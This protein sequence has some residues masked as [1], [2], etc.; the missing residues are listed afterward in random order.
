[1]ANSN[2]WCLQEPWDWQRL[3]IGNPELQSD[4]IT[5]VDGSGSPRLLVPAETSIRM[6]GAHLP[7][8]G[9]LVADGS[10]GLLASLALPG[11]RQPALGLK[12]LD[13][14]WQSDR[15]RGVIKQ[16]DYL[17]RPPRGDTS[18]E[19]EPNRQ[20]ECFILWAIGR[21]QELAH[22]EAS[23]GTGVQRTTW[24]IARSVWRDYDAREP[25]MDLIVRL[26]KDQEL[27]EALDAVSRNPR[28]VLVRVRDEVRVD[29][30][31]ELDAACIRSYARRP[32]VTAVEKAGTRQTLLAVRRQA[33]HDTL[34]NRVTAWTLDELTGCSQRWLGQHRQARTSEKT[35]I[36]RRLAQECPV[37]RNGEALAPVG[38]ASLT[39][40]TQP[41]YPLQFAERYQRVYAAYLKLLKQRRE[42]D[43]A[44]TWRRTLW[45]DVVRQLVATT[46]LQLGPERFTSHPHYRGES[47]H[48]SWLAHPC[49]PGP[50]DVGSRGEWHVLDARDL[51]TVDSSWRRRPPEPWMPS[52]GALGADLWLWCLRPQRLVPIWAILDT[53]ATGD[54]KRVE[55]AAEA[56][57]AWQQAPTSPTKRGYVVHGLIVTSRP[58]ASMVDLTTS[59]VTPRVR[60]A[61]LSLPLALGLADSAHYRR[62]LDDVAA[63]IDLALAG[64]PA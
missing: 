40:P 21:F 44:W 51:A 30:V 19:A 7:V 31:Q 26:A 53:A 1:M 13:L 52:L 28:R 11:D 47:V 34:E 33:S 36:V 4:T 49:A 48:G 3:G 23:S 22:G 37:R 41:N 16:A 55:R 56:L 42:E 10:G 54:S 50:L 12:D 39:H 57:D 35:A 27:A 32:G 46:L 61:S 6:R 24:T 45:A 14:E 60:V 63:G 59:I 18:P 29:R 62:M 25:T 15:G 38:T 2:G 9:P 64:V 58:S 5:A 43:D 17:A 8:C 20:L